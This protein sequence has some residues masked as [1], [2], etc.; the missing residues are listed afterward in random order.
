[1]RPEINVVLDNIRSAHN[2]GAIFRTGDGAGINKLFLCGITPYP[3]HNRIPKTALGA[4]EFVEWERSV[5]TVDVLT[6]LKE[7]GHTIFAVEQTPE[8][9]DF[10]SI[11][12]PTKSTF[13]FG[14]EI[15]GVAPEVLA[16]ADHVIELPMHGQK[17]SLNVATTVGIVL[18]FAR[19]RIEHGTT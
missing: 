10:T 14:H 4:I 9:K 16:I 11:D 12:Y 1:M 15:T 18:Y 19:Y 13:V 7:Q 5:S 2:V 3:P 8:S 17:N 6:R